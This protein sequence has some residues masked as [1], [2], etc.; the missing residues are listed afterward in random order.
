MRLVLGIAIGVVFNRPIRTVVR[1]TVQKAA[2][3][4]LDVIMVKYVAPHETKII[5][6]IHEAGEKLR[7]KIIPMHRDGVYDQYAK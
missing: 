4:V 7:E 1:K 5:D 2:T 6:G 3:P